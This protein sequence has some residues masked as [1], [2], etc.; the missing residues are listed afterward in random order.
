ML[1]ATIER[2]NSI[3]TLAKCAFKGLLERN[4][5]HFTSMSATLLSK[6]GCALHWLIW[7]PNTPYSQLNQCTLDSWIKDSVRWSAV[8]HLRS[9]V[10]NIVIKAWL[11]L[12]LAYSDTKH[13]VVSIESMHTCFLNNGL[14]QMKRSCP[15]EEPCSAI[16]HGVKQTFRHI[17]FYFFRTFGLPTL[18]SFG[19]RFEEF[20]RQPLRRSVSH[21]NR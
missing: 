20:W 17:P 15:F 1:E 19:F 13:L 10:K 16:K 9:C 8:A 2:I 12:A 4:R 21:V 18:F 7:T 6:L 14:F 3:L 11:R 5:I